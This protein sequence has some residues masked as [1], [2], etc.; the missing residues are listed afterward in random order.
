[1]LALLFFEDILIS[2]LGQTQTP[3]AVCT[4]RG[5]VEC[6]LDWKPL[7][8]GGSLSSMI[9]PHLPWIL[10]VHQHVNMLN[11]HA[12]CVTAQAYGWNAMLEVMN[13]SLS[14][15]LFHVFSFDRVTDGLHVAQNDA[16]VSVLQSLHELQVVADLEALDWLLLQTKRKNC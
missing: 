2:T 15:F 11:T 10:S 16:P 12:Q 6:S 1:M 3:C 4:F 13:K 9:H 7:Y 8:P 14:R 5:F